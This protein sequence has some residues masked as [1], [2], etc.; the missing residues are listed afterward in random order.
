MSRQVVLKH[1]QLD[2][3]FASLTSE[4]PPSA[5]E[6]PSM[7]APHEKRF[8]YGLAKQYWRGEGIIVDAGIF[9]GG[10]TRCF[11]DG[12]RA[13]PALAKGRRV[14]EKPIV[15]FEKGSMNPGMVPHLERKGITITEDLRRNFIPL[16]EKF[17]EPVSDL[18]DLRPGDIMET[19]ETIDQ[20]IEICFLDVL[21]TPE[22]SSYCLSKFMPRLIPGRS[23]VIQQD[24]FFEQL[25]YIKTHQ[26]FLRDH[27]T[28]I[29]EICSSAA[30]LC[31]SPIPEEKLAQIREGIPYE[32]SLKLA[33]IAMQ[34]SN[35]PARRFMMAISKLRM[36]EKEE[37]PEAAYLRM[38]KSD[39]P[40][41][42]G[43][44]MHKRLVDSLAAAERLLKIEK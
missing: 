15:S 34:R 3:G 8:L 27:F 32:E 19:A 39:F 13:N 40:E 10:S 24:Y 30:F 26:E 1:V 20:P 35:D 44:T 18:V 5:G 28:Y 2:A 22:I 7:M 31:T 4:M 38:I 23:V 36:I 41:Q 33:G 16:V 11:G 6:V 17:I 25:P 42:A 9:L 29:G 37:G 12:L 14:K 43:D 21:K